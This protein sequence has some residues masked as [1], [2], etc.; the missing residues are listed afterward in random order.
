[1]IAHY[2]PTTLK[3][4]GPSQAQNDFVSWSI[5]AGHCN[6]PG[7]ESKHDAPADGVYEP[8]AWA[9]SPGCAT[10]AGRLSLTHARLFFKL[11]AA[12]NSC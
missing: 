11:T 4:Q 3:L 7:S 8:A 5:Y 2:N 9:S 6:C 10:C 12:W 1:M